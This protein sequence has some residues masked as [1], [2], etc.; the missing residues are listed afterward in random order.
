MKLDFHIVAD[1]LLD[2]EK[3]AGKKLKQIMS[4][5][6]Y[7][8]HDHVFSV[9]TDTARFREMVSLM[10]KATA[11]LADQ[12]D[13]ELDDLEQEAIHRLA[14]AYCFTQLCKEFSDTINTLLEAVANGFG[15][16]TTERLPAVDAH[17]V[18]SLLTGTI[19][20]MPKAKKKATDDD[21]LRD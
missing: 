21:F 20:V 16:Q 8:S 3:I 10:Q 15:E 5:T 1:D 6:E 17:K 7:D 4:Y 2:V 12:S 11:S 19:K 14:K 9:V 18:L 13:I